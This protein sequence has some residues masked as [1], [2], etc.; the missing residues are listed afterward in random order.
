MGVDNVENA[1]PD[2]EAIF[3]ILNAMQVDAGDAIMVGDMPVD[4]AMGHNAA[5][6]TCAVTY[7]N[8]S[9]ADL[10][11]SSP[12]YLIDDLIQLLAL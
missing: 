11:K 7:G 1:K 6:K 5:I 12:D 8:S 2:P 4:I 3:H 9:R 10:E